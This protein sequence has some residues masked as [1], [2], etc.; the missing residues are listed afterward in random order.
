MKKIVIGLTGASG[1]IIFKKLIEA[2]V[3]KV[4]I[5]IVT[6]NYGEQVFNFEIGTPINK[7]IADLNSDHIHL[8]NNSNMFAS[9]AS[10]SFE[11]D[12]MI[13]AP[14]SMGTLAKIANG[15]GDNLLARAADVTIKEQRRLLLV[16]REAP[17]SAIH[18]EN[19][20]NLSKLGVIIFPPN[21]DFYNKPITIDETVNNMVGRILSYFDINNN[22]KKVWD[23]T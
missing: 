13:I 18:L 4:E 1:S 10:G 3:N 15:T 8:H 23:N 7:F 9:I 2:L 11:V 22:L 6:S 14:C 20:L 21:P 17:L 5:H 12:G 19:M 16:T